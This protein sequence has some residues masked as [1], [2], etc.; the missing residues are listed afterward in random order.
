M[1]AVLL[2]AACIAPHR[3]DMSLRALADPDVAIGR[4]DCERADARQC[5]LVMD[6]LAGGFAISKTASTRQP[7]DPDPFGIDVMQ[8]RDIGCVDGIERQRRGQATPR[9][10]AQ[11]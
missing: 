3:L 4:R 6:K 5:R 7:P 8:A 11:N 10:S 9:L 1:I 2:A